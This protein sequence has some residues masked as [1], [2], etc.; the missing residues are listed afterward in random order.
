MS[1]FVEGDVG[2]YPA[3]A[4]G[5]VYRVSSPTSPFPTLAW[6][7]DQVVCVLLADSDRTEM[8]VLQLI[9]PTPADEIVSVA[10]R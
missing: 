6:R 9:R 4:S 3:L 7:N 1:L 8:A 10:K 2:Q 5:R